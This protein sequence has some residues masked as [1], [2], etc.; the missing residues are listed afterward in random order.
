MGKGQRRR[1]GRRGEGED[2]G[3]G[4]KPSGAQA[5]RFKQPTASISIIHHKISLLDYVSHLSPE[6]PS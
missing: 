2:G 3:M 4:Q 5:S 1:R 6:R